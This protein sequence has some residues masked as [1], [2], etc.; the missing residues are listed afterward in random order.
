[1]TKIVYPHVAIVGSR[2]YPSYYGGFETLVRKLAPFLADNG[3]KVTVYSR[4]RI[5]LGRQNEAH[6]GVNVVPNWGLETKSLSTL[7]HGLSAACGTA[8]MRPDVAL[9]LNVANGFYLPLLKL[10]KVPTLVN[11]DGIEW[12]REKWG[13]TARQIF[14]AGARATATWAD[15]L[16]MDSTAIALRWNQ[17]F[18]RTGHYIPYGGDKVADVPPPPG[19]ER[20]GYVLFVA[21]LVP[22]NTVG[23]FMEA[24]RKLATQWPVVVVGSSGYRGP[25][26]QQLRSL[27]KEVPG[28][29]WF[30]QIKNDALLHALWNNAGVYFHGHS[31]G[32][33][34]PALVQAMHCGSPTVARDTV[35]NREVLQQCGLYVAPDPGSIVDVVSELMVDY[36]W[37][38][39]LARRARGRA[40]ENFGWDA[41]AKSYH[42]AL[43]ELIAKR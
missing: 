1:M 11:V 16:V 21:R 33:T 6:A 20:R 35:Y 32:G 5:D 36:Q 22:E 43:T 41:V 19:L 37:Q 26:E 10:R 34:N 17:E 24:A 38:E 8:T 27:V 30:G 31:V 29:S 3:W 39:N 25:V 18:K 13:R 12:E 42:V 4:E 15:A 40:I 28:I 14:L 7:S 23:S 9:V 2:G